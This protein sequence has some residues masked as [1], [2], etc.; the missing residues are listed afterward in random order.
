MAH[1]AKSEH[2][3]LQVGERG[4]LVLPAQVRKRLALK[5]GAH[6]VLTIEPDGRM[7]LMPLRDQVHKARGL[8]RDVAPGRNLADEL[9]DERRQEAHKERSTR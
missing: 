9:I 8:W 4:R 2:Y 1:T 3:D 5:G 6:L 7:V